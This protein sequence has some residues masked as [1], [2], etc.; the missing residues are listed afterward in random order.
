MFLYFVWKNKLLDEKTFGQKVFRTNKLS[1]KSLSECFRFYCK[2][3]CR[4]G[5]HEAVQRKELALPPSCCSGY[6][7]TDEYTTYATTNDEREK[8]SVVK[9][10]LRFC[11]MARVPK[12]SLIE[13]VLF[14][15]CG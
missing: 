6:C 8:N 3:N 13:C 10:N 5:G 1:D 15:C 2:L 11:L 7:V 9:Q 14:G 4:I 12:T